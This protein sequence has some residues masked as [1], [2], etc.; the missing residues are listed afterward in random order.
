PEVPLESF[1]LDADFNRQYREEERLG[2]VAGTFTVMGLCVACLGLLGLASFT[3][4][5]R[6]K[7]IGIRKVLGASVPGILLLL[8]RHYLKSILV[9]N[10]IAWPLAWW[11]MDLW[12]NRFVTQMSIHIWPFLLAGAG[13]LLIALI[14]VSVQSVRAAIANPSDSLRYE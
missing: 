12:L 1:F 10:I 6:T 13:T 14:T 3:A 4:A 11:A 7:E 8:S 9:A 5:Q 2:R